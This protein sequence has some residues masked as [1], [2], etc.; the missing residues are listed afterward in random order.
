MKSALNWIWLALASA[1]VLVGF[2]LLAKVYW[3]LFMTGWE[4][5]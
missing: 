3:L 1:A 5:L 4:L 2:G